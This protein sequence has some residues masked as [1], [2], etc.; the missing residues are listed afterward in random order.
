MILLLCVSVSSDAQ[1]LSEMAV[2]LRMLDLRVSHT[3]CTA[4]SSTVWSLPGVKGLHV[5]GS[6]DVKASP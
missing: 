6:S 1:T 5:A 3:D 2:S 4:L